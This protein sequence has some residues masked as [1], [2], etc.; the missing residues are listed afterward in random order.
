MIL[1]DCKKEDFEEDLTP[2]Q[3]NNMHLYVRV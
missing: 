1:L 3:T 2:E